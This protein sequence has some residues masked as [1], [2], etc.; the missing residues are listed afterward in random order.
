MAVVSAICYRSMK[1]K[2]TPHSLQ[3]I[4]GMDQTTVSGKCSCVAG[5]GG[6]CHHVVGLLFTCHTVSNLGLPD[7]LTCTMMAQRWSVP[8]GNHISPQCVDALMVKKPQE[9]ANYD[10]FIKITLYSPASQYHIPGPNKKAKL[11]SLNHEPLLWSLLPDLE[12]LASSQLPSVQTKFGMVPKGSVISYQQ[13]LTKKYVI[14]NYAQTTFP[15]LPLPDAGERFKNNVSICL[16]SNKLAKLESLS[17]TLEMAHALE[18][19]KPENRMKVTFG[20]HYEKKESLQASLEL[21][22]EEFLILIL[23]LNNFS[24][25]GL[26]RQLL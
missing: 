20:I 7:D 3:V 21:W 15:K 4:I 16:N 13:R 25:L 10:K 2:E 1:K 26:Y 9:G 6:I 5:A 24:H 23:W 14:N 11:K 18:K 22:Q 19:K 8:R 12:N 17:V